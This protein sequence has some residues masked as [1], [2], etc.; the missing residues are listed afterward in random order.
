MPPNA[1]AYGASNVMYAPASAPAGPVSGLNSSA[2]GNN[3]LGAPAL[4]YQP[5]FNRHPAAAC[6]SAYSHTPGQQQYGNGYGMP[7]SGLMPALSSQQYNNA[8]ASPTR[9]LPPAMPA[10]YNPQ[11]YGHFQPGQKGQV[12]RSI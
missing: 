11:T 12:R 4:S 8:L 6:P 3:Q 1:A 10:V 9:A 7:T 5:A 2:L